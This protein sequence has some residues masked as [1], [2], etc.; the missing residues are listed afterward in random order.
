M[1]ISASRRTD[2]PAFYAEW[3]MNRIRAGYVLTRNPFNAKQVR[4]VSLAPED[5]DAIVFWTRNPRQ[6]LPHLQELDALGYRYYFQFTITGYPRILES[7][8]PRPQNAVELF[9]QLSD[10]IGPDRVVWRYDPILLSSLVNLS[11]HKRL[12]AK[13]AGLLQGKSRTVVVSFAD[14]YDKVKR[15]LAS[16]P[17]LS[18]E[19]VVQQPDAVAEL[20]SFMAHVAAEHGMAIQS[21]AE[22]I[23][24]STLG[25]PH[26]KCIDDDLIRRALGVDVSRRKDKGQREA[27]GCVES[28]DIGQYNSCLHGCS[29]CYAT[30]NT[31][32]ARTNF[33]KHHPD[34][35]FLIGLPDPV[36]SHVSSTDDENSPQGGLF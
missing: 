20:S 26:G 9:S 16:V 22:E 18:H 1:I 29:Y 24:L 13:I 32:L 34:S 12:F 33:D 30:S 35:P 14:I 36:P 17:D 8:V 31:R 11:E 5:V 19:D 2:I 15:N 21:C 10:L 3:F 6:L 28:I 27:C 23:D 4:T 7:S 25:I